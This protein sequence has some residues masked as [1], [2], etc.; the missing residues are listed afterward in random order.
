MIS[1]GK[2]TKYIIITAFLWATVPIYN[3]FELNIEIA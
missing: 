3:Y 1:I 2:S